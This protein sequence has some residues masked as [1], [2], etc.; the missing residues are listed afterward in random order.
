MFAEIT[1]GNKPKIAIVGSGALG[2]YV[3]AYLT[4]EGHDVTLIICASMG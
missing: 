4:R 1:L 3:G 2:G